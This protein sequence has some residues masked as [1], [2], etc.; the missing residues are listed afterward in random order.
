MV[1]LLDIAPSTKTVAIGDKELAVYGVSAHGIAYLIGRFP[2]LRDLMGGTRDGQQV[3]AL[4]IAKVVP[5]AIASIIAAG[6]GLP[7]NPDA[8]TRA[9]GLPADTQLD[10]VNAVLELTMPKGAGPFF[11]KLQHVMSAFD[12]SVKAQDTTSQSQSSS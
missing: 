6:C 4:K 2:E 7:N 11:A 9:S 10:I 3:D 5:D 8:E 1:G 12:V